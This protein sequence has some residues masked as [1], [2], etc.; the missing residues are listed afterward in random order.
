MSRKKL[1]EHHAT[2]DK[3][4]NTG[5][6]QT[7]SSF[8]TESG[9]NELLSLQEVEKVISDARAD[10]MTVI[11]VG[12]QCDWA[13]FMVIATGRVIVHAL[14]KKASYYNMENLWTAKMVQKESVEELTKAFVKSQYLLLAISD[15]GG[16]KIPISASICN[17]VAFILPHN[18]SWKL[19]FS[20]LNQTFSSSGME[21]GSK[22]LL[23]LQEVEKVLRDV[24]AD[25]MMVIPVGKQC[26]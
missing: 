16:C 5:L 25:D 2:A 4:H 1:N 17:I 21:S 6:N 12:K 13:D 24:R 9:S 15:V 8:S 10:D 11:P 26:D 20:G 3:S 7:F 22:E 19:G 14:D 23:S 18:R